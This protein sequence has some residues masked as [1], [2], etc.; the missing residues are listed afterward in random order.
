MNIE[1]KVWQR[2]KSNHQTVQLLAENLGLSRV[3]AQIMAN[4]G[5]V[6]LEEA[7]LFLEPQLKDLHDPLMLKGM[8]EAIERIH[9]AI[10]NQE[11]IWVY[12]DYDVDGITSISVVL[13]T[14]EALGY[15]IQYYIPNRLEEGYGIG[16]T[17]LDRIAEKGGQLI[18]SVD[19]GI[20]AVNEVEYAKSLGLDFIISDH[21]ECQSQIPDAVAVINPKQHDCSYPY[22]M[23]AGVGVAFKLCQ[24]LI[25]DM[26]KRELLFKEL[27]SIVALGTVADIAPVNGENRI[28]V[29]HGI[30][31]MKDAYNVGLRKLIEAS[32]I[33]NKKITTGH[34]GF[35]LGPRINATGRVGE[36]G[37][38]VELLMTSNPQEAEKIAK[39]LSDLNDERQEIERLIL[40]EAIE[41]IESDAS[42]KEDRVLVVAKEGW[43][44]GIVGIVASKICERY[45]KPVILL[46]IEDGIAKGSARSIPE[47]SIFTGL[48]KASVHLE[49]FGGHELAAGMSLKADNIKLLRQAI[50]AY[51]E[52]V[53]TEFDM[54]PKIKV[55]T[56]LESKDVNYQ[57]LD[58]IEKM[59]PFGIGNPKPVFA[60]NH[61]I[62]DQKRTMGKNREHIK[63]MTHD[64]N[65]VFESVGFHMDMP[66][67]LQSG[68][69]IDLAFQVDRNEFNGVTSLQFLLKDYRIKRQSLPDDNRYIA[70]Y[71]DT[72]S[73]SLRQSLENQEGSNTFFIDFRNKGNKDK[74]VNNLVDED[75]KTL[76]LVHSSSGLLE[77]LRLALDFGHQHWFDQIAFNYLTGTLVT[78][79]SILVNPVY[80]ALELDLFDQVILYDTPYS[81][82]H[83]EFLTNRC[84]NLTV[85][86]NRNDDLNMQKMIHKVIPDRNDLA[87]LY[88]SIK[89]KSFKVD[90]YSDTEHLMLKPQQEIGL[91]VLE[92]L[93][94]IKKSANDEALLYEVVP[95]GNKKINLFDTEIYT[96][97]QNIKKQYDAFMLV[98]QNKHF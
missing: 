28:L 81:Q 31:S 30:D 43:H 65:R 23:L 5:L 71:F 13:K 38:G 85:L 95:Q 22:D 69:I 21:H 86:Y 36:P 78:N 80:N 41:L 25:P 12:G 51:A 48:Q 24:A 97:V 10:Q 82:N 62:L 74:I 45:Y 15:P 11:N 26:D 70:T 76:L 35:R 19:C 66:E 56:E 61:M 67:G 96:A 39:E 20:T 2:R 87:N 40:G 47:F 64:G 27:L 59:E 7:K 50:N 49:G 42:Y 34:I 75:R 98:A 79:V 68:S 84:K 57:L 33:K 77:V 17:G 73:E 53:L 44:T 4:R 16:K 58:D 46:R 63:L 54:I 1:S 90:A 8:L 88:V 89:N 3:T 14:F 37:L 94:L 9:K 60:Y 72:L 18:I 52:T 6:T 29:K 32:G 91:S 92:T 83:F 93:K 55:D